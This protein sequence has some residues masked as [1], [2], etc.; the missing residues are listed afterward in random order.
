LKKVFFG[1]FFE[2][3]KIFEGVENL[4][5]FSP[6]SYVIKMFYSGVGGILAPEPEAVVVSLVNFSI[7]SFFVL[8]N[9]KIIKECL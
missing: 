6:I 8:S 2:S 7:F 3:F 9:S 4:N 1:G 5:S